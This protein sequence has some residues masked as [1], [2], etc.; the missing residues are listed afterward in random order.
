MTPAD[1]DFVCRFVRDRAALVLEPGKEYLVETRLTPIVRT[2]GLESISGLVNRLRTNPA[3]GLA[4]RVVEAMVTTE[5]LFFRD[6][7][8][9]ESLRTTVVPELIERRAG[10]RRLSIWSAACS[11]G[12]EPYSL[13][14]LLREHFP[15]LA[16]WDVRILATDISTDVLAKAKAGRYS[17]IE[18]NRGLP[19][20]LLLKYFRQ[21]GTTWELN[22]D[23]RRAVEFRE[24]N[25]AT[26]WPPL[27]MFDLVFLR[28]VM[29][30]FDVPTKKAI[31]GRLVKQLRLG[32]Y[33][34]LGGA[35]TTFGLDDSFRRVDKVKG[36]FYQLGD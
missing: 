9:Y 3:D 22:E 27:P 30:Y 6:H 26:A 21:H 18:V 31:L 20:G 17:Q 4:A 35:E 10:D 25:L 13:A 34:L 19:A 23:V 24:L 1:F 36:G 12:Q 15:Q 2:N 33:V 28:N 11:T 8:P 14:I 29:I 7:Q 32:A 5:T 16:G